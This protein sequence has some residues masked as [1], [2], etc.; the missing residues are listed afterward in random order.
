MRKPLFRRKDHAILV[1]L[2]GAL[3]AFVGF[4]DAYQSRGEQTP[5]PLRP[6]LPW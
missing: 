6:F 4:R 3:L 1:G 2:A 5:A